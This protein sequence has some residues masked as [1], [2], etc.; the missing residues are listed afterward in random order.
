MWKYILLC[1]AAL[2]YLLS[3]VALIPD[4]ALGLGQIDDI[5]LLVLVFLQAKRA[6][7]KF[8]KPKADAPSDPAKPEV[9]AEGHELD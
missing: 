5:I 3:P 7:K 2:A 4:F 8:K 6:Y 1:L 9:E